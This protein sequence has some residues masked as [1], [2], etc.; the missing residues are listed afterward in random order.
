MR[1]KST[2]VLIGLLF[3]FV[4]QTILFTNCS[5]RGFQTQFD[6][7]VIS[8]SSLSSAD[9]LPNTNSVSLMFV[10]KPANLTKE[11]IPE[12]D[13]I[14]Q[15][16]SFSLH[17][18]VNNNELS[19]CANKISLPNLSDGDYQVRVVAVDNTGKILSEI[20]HAFKV[21]RKPP[22]VSI[23]QAPASLISTTTATVNFVVNDNLAGV[24]YAECSFDEKSYEACESPVNLKNLSV[25][26][27]SFAVKA[28]D[29]LGNVSVSKEVSFAVNFSAPNIN[30]TT[31]PAALT[32][33]KTAS[34]AF[35]ASSTESS[36]ASYTCELD[37][38]ATSCTSPKTYTSLNEG[39]RVFKVTAIDSR[40]MESSLVYKWSI[41]SL[42]PTS[43][44][45]NASVSSPT[46]LTT[47][48]LTFSSVDPSGIEKYECRVN[49]EAYASC[50][51]PKTY[52]NLPTGTTSVFKV[53]ATDKIGNVSPEATYSVFVEAPVII[54]ISNYPPEQILKSQPSYVSMPMPGYLIPVLD[55]STG[56]YYTRITDS[57]V[58][59]SSSSYLRHHYA[60]DQPWNS[61]GTLL[62]LKYGNS[63]FLLD[64][65]T[66]K[67]IKTIS[68][69][70]HPL[71]SNVNP[72]IMYGLF[73]TNVVKYNVDTNSSATMRSFSDYSNIQFGP[74][75]GNLSKD[76]KY[77]CITGYKSTGIDFMLYNIA[78]NVIEGV[79]PFPG[80]VDSD[81]DWC[82]VSQSGNYVIIETRN[83]KLT[84]DNKC[85]IKV[86]DKQ[87]KFQRHL[88]STC[89]GHADM[90]YD[91][92]GNEVVVTQDASG[93]TAF[94]SYRLS[95]GTRR[96]ELPSSAMTWNQHVSCRNLARPGYC[97][98]S[99]YAYYTGRERYAYREIFALK[100]NGTGTIERFAQ[101]HFDE[102][103]TQTK[104]EHSSMAVPNRN[105]SIVLWASEWES[106]T[107]KVNTFI[108]S[109][110]K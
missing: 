97:Y 2:W 24:D 66:F 61:D 69:P 104:Y 27:H 26:A 95:D 43:P 42:P 21:D 38:V 58:F 71:W 1:K 72:K 33:S 6:S 34:F 102:T 78:D 12:L 108:S 14:V 52:S 3:S 23:N 82:S 77:I 81:I 8:Q 79:L 20:S 41:D 91:L 46:K 31:N 90:G 9:N 89:G 29:K 32:S 106:S 19:S 88:V 99:T 56:N 60:K 4:L 100:L 37:G 68:T 83:G 76:D 63:G 92:S 94:Y 55:K 22:E 49:S 30:L 48:N 47:I 35:T 101:A 44:S 17:C 39:E 73:G 45:L 18:Y 7:E 65:K 84:P 86:Y 10:S 98:V 40:K 13:F 109:A 62:H 25:G 70:F 51:S 28:Y 105:G 87:M 74:S 67:Y 110:S 54:P 103:V 93:D 107:N 85:G 57:I 64:G 11:A 36:I 80:G 75:E 53:R 50:L 15:G 16:N 96:L 5:P 59:N